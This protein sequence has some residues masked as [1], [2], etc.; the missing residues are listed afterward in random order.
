MKRRFKLS[1]CLLVAVMLIAVGLIAVA[2]GFTQENKGIS[3][4]KKIPDLGSGAD[5]NFIKD[6]ADQYDFIGTV[7][8]V[9]KEGIVVDDSYFK[10]ASG[11]KISGARKG[12]Q[13]GLVI[14]GAGEI[15]ICEPYRKSRR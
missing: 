3:A 5:R 6:V 2:P 10:T 12:T 11:A 7:N 1:R 14:N 4:I 13:V 8:A 15:V 9:Q